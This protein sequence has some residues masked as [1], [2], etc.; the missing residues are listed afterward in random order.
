MKDSRWILA[1]DGSCAKCTRISDLVAEVAGDRLDTRPLTDADVIR[2][3]HD[4]L[5]PAAPWQPTLIRVTGGKAKSWTGPALAVPMARVLGPRATV[6]VLRVLGEFAAA[7]SAARRSPDGVAAVVAQGPSRRG[8]LLAG[9]GA[10]LAGWLVLGRGTGTAEASSAHRW[11]QQNL[12]SLPQDLDGIAEYPMTYRRA[13][14]VQLPAEVQSRLWTEHLARARAARE[15]LSTEQ[16][17]ALRR[18][19]DLAADP[20]TFRG[21]RT[22]ELTIRRAPPGAPAAARLAPPQPRTGP[23]G[24][25]ADAPAG[26]RTPRG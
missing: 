5:G 25:G 18:I 2:W 24:V 3:R 10:V 23:G 6:R 20:A 4:S 9:S 22:D 8:V 12:G 16:D 14:I 15:R 7:E 13:A 26:A 1:F 17:A 11:V 21:E 19:E